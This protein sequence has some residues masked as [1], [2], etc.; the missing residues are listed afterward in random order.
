MPEPVAALYRVSTLKQAKRQD[1]LSVQIALVQNY[2]SSHDMIITK[3]YKEEGVS[4]F[5]NEVSERAILRQILMDAAAGA[6]NT[7]LI[8]KSDRLARQSFG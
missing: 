1:D 5:H 2:A 4:A 8:F 6:F 7:L 3:Q